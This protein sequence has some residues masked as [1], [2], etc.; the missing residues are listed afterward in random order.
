MYNVILIFKLICWD[1]RGAI[2]NPRIFSKAEAYGVAIEEQGRKTLHRYL[3]GIKK[4]QYN[5]K[6][7]IS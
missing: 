2:G 6:F 5:K 1:D 7:T 4:N 3:F